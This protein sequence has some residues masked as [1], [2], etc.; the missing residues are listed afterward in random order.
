LPRPPTARAHIVPW[1]RV[2]ATSV[3]YVLVGLVLGAF[4]VSTLPGVRPHPGY[5][6]FFDGILNNVA[7]ELSAVVC[8]VRAGRAVLFV[9]SYRYLGVGLALYGAGNIFW[10]IFIRTQDPEPFPSAADVLWLSF[11]AFAFIAIWLIVREIAEGVPVSLWLDG[12]VAGLAVAG[13]AAA[14]IGP[15]LAITGAAR[16]KWS[17]PSLTRS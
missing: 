17:R 1:R 10:T 14:F 9:R 8:F 5:N 15:V 13:V 6:L 12:V 16:P 4:V 2:S 7:Y 3:L 11:Y